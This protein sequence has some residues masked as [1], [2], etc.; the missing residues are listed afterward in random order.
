MSRVSVSLFSEEGHSLLATRLIGSVRAMLG[1]E[2][3]IRVVFES[4]SVAGM[5]EWIATTLWALSP[6]FKTSEAADEQEMGVI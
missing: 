5:A 3:P 2:L 1:V 4:P 6:R